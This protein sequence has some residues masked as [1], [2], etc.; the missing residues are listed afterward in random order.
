MSVCCEFT[1]VLICCQKNG[2]KALCYTKSL[3]ESFNFTASFWLQNNH[4]KFT[5][6]IHKNGL[7]IH[8]KD[9]C[10]TKINLSQKFIIHLFDKSCLLLVQWGVPT[11]SPAAVFGM[12]A[13]V[14]ASAV[15]S[16]GDYYACARLSGAP[17]PPVHAI[18][19]LLDLEII[20]IFFFQQFIRIKIDFFY[21]LH[22]ILRIQ[23]AYKTSLTLFS[24]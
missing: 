24:F 16:V 10:Y 6:R 22:D 13:G 20:F 11:V 4:C 8:I 18:N 19:R 14:L 15:E 3:P 2:I 21:N 17:R 7:N 1:K 12:M 9:I 23:Y 5:K